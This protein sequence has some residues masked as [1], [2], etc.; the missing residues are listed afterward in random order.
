MLN[1]DT[2]SSTVV[3]SR[4]VIIKYVKTNSKSFKSCGRYL[5]LL[6]ETFERK[7]K[8]LI[9]NTT[10]YF[11]SKKKYFL[12]KIPGI[13]NSILLGRHIVVSVNFLSVCRMH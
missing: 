11:I 9:R 2:S 5:L 3:P 7:K 1:L 13:N 6:L 12:C 8:E 4:L 10:H